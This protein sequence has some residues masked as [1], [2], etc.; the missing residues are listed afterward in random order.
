MRAVLEEA[1][2]YAAPPSA[3]VAE[4]HKEAAFKPL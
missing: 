1:L 2:V 4:R 3:Q